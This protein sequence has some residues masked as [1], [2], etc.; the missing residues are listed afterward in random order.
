MAT[1]QKHLAFGSTL[2][3]LDLS[4]QPTEHQETNGKT[5]FETE[6]ELMVIELKKSL[7]AE[8]TRKL[9]GLS[10]QDLQRLDGAL[11]QPQAL[12]NYLAP[13]PIVSI[14]PK[15]PAQPTVNPQIEKLLEELKTQGVLIP[16]PDQV[17]SYLSQYPSLMEKLPAIC[18]KVKTIPQNPA[19]FSLEVRKSIESQEEVFT[20]YVRQNQYDEQLLSKLLDAME[21]FEEWH[22]RQEG[23]IFVTTDFQ[24]PVTERQRYFTV[25]EYL[26]FERSSKERHLWVDGHI[27]AMA[28]GSRSHNTICSNLAGEVHAQLKGK[29]CQ[30][31][32]SNTKVRSGDIPKGKRLSKGMISY[33]DLTVVCG[34][35]LY[36]DKYEDVL[37]N[38]KV[39][40]EVLSPG[41]QGFDETEK[42]RRYRENL[43]SLTDY[44]LVTQERLFIEHYTRQENGDWVLQT[45]SGLDKALEL[46]S[47]E[48]TLQL[49]ELY[50]RLQFPSEE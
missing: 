7:I 41:T 31:F 40:F 29:D 13:R 8:I 35:Q 19:E 23:W 43:D 14:T 46:P 16:E 34:E 4:Q 36:H 49:S 48:C 18:T 45:I 32:T 5:N 9:Q 28:G 37:L 27:Y 39:I 24:L 47:I 21:E 15:Q 25:E 17:K 2:Y 50:A 1:P 42:F 22:S 26:S 44:V 38:P 12:A 20:L 11:T 10:I 3:S 33:P 30:S 6:I